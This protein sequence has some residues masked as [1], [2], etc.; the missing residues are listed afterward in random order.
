MTVGVSRRGRLRIGCLIKLRRVESKSTACF[1]HRMIRCVRM[2]V[3]TPSR[4]YYLFFSSGVCCARAFE[5][6]YNDPLPAPGDEYKIMV[7]RSTSPTG[8][9]V[10]DIGRDCAT[11][12]GGR[13][14]LGS[15]GKHVYAPGGQGVLND[16]KS[17]RMVLYYHYQDPTVSYRYEEFLFGFNYME[18]DGDGWPVVV[19][20]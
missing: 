15:H 16:S 1:K 14:V 8:P 4:Y 6:T 12:D 5:G 18:I 10:D 17:G 19:A 20:N 7:C 11:S 13:L 2:L 9:F 3:L